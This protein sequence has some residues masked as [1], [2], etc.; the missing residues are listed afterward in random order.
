[1]AAELTTYFSGLVDAVDEK[2]EIADR[3]SIVVRATPEQAGL[4]LTA[5]VIDP[6]ASKQPVELFGT[7]RQITC[8]RGALWVFTF[9]P[10][11]SGL[12]SEVAALADRAS[13]EQPTVAN[14]PHP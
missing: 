5:H 3:E 9:A 1:V 10:E 13:C 8:P 12:K 4:V 7:A 6:F 14:A 2:D 11:R